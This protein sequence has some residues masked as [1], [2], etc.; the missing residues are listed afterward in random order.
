M[1]CDCGVLGCLACGLVETWFYLV[2]KLSLLRVGSRIGWLC[3]GILCTLSSGWCGV[4]IWCGVRLR[5]D[6]WGLFGFLSGVICAFD[7]VGGLFIVAAG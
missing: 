6:L 4:C 7:A 5:G 1:C 2:L 3:V